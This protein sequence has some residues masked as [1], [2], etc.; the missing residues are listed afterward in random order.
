MYCR[1]CGAANPD[2]SRFCGA[3]GGPIGEVPARPLDGSEALEGQRILGYRLERKLGEGGMGAVYLGVNETIGQQV[4]IKILDSILARNAE[5]RERFV[6]EARIQIGL[7]H[8]NIVR[9]LTADTEGPHLALVMEYVDGLTLGQ[10]IERRGALPLAEAAGLFEQ[11]LDAMSFAH[12]RGVVHRDLKPS[13]VMVQADGTAM[14][15]DFGIAKVV[16]GNKLTRTGTAMGSVQYMSPEQVMGRTDI[17]LRTDIYSLGITFYEVLVGRTPFEDFVG[18][19]T[20]SDYLIKDAHVRQTPPDPRKF[21]PGLTEAVVKVLLC[22]LHK[23]PAGRHD[24]CQA[25][26]SELTGCMGSSEPEPMKDPEEQAK[27][28]QAREA[29]ER[30]RIVA[31]QNKAEAARVEAERRKA[32]ATRKEAERRKAE[33]RKKEATLRWSETIRKDQERLKAEIARKDVEPQK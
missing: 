22:T 9:V 26:W 27:Q 15:T 13:N 24:S 5:I 3:C 4:A 28:Q 8:P 16:G 29:A 25:L 14:I 2:E 30:A 10:V 20:D 31:E 6:Q 23:E 21:R 7:R 18:T 19:T 11:I 1:R 33:A 12:S 17:D 32:D